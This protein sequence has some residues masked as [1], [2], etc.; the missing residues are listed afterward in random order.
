MPNNHFRE[1]WNFFTNTK[2]Y[3]LLPSSANIHSIVYKMIRVQK[4][5]IKSVIMTTHFLQNFGALSYSFWSVF[6]RFVLCE[7]LLVH[8]TLLNVTGGI[9]SG[10]IQ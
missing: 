1:Y 5:N 4:R 9:C 7:K 3:Y 6:I 8:G 2:L 10:H